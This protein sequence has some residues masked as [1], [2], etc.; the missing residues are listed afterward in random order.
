[1]KVPKICVRCIGYNVSIK[2]FTYR[3]DGTDITDNCGAKAA[4]LIKFS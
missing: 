1:M 2:D 4:D 3:E